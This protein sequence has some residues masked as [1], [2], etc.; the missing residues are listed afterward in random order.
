[1]RPKKLCVKLGADKS[2]IEHTTLPIYVIAL[3][4]QLYI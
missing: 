4:G 1:M 3:Y 2:R